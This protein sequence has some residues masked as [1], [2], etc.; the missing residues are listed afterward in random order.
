MKSRIPVVAALVLGLTLLTAAGV[1]AQM[2]KDPKTGLDRIEGTIQSINKEKSTLTVRQ[3]G[4]GNP[5]WLVLYNAKTAFSM[6]NEKAKMEDLKDGLRVIV[7]G[8][9]ADDTLTAARIDIRTEQ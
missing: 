7:L 9:F 4:G 3:S 2:K 6:R 5:V 1:W 8:K